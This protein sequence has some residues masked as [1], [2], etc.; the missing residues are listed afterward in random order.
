MQPSSA[1]PTATPPHDQLDSDGGHSRGGSRE[2][3]EKALA[4]EVSHSSSAALFSSAWGSLGK[5]KRILPAGLL[6]H[7]V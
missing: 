7:A 5:I 6:S 3:A 1:T 2:P 4:L